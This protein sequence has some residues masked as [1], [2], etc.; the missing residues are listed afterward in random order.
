M[1]EQTTRAG[2]T[3]AP[4]SYRQVFIAAFGALALT[5]ASWFLIQAPHP[6][7]ASSANAVKP[8]RVM[9]AIEGMS[10]TSCANGIKAM[11]KR[12]PGVISAEVSFERREAKVEY[13]SERTTREKIVEA[14]SKLGYQATVKG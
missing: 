5:A 3:L 13:D 14:I 10:C 2:K 7:A 11:L 6:S 9:I 1:V 4:S 12:T 8:E